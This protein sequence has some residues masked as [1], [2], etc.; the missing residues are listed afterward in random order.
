[1]ITTIK[2]CFK[3]QRELP[4][5]SFY[6]HPMMTGGR[7]G[8]CK[9]CARKDVSENRAKKADYYNEF[10]RARYHALSKEDL[11]KRN[12]ANTDKLKLKPGYKELKKQ[13]IDRSN[14]KHIDKHRAR[15]ALKNAVRSGIVDRPEACWHCG[16]QECVHGHHSAYDLPLAVTWL[17]SFCHGIAHRLT[18]EVL[19]IEQAATQQDK[20]VA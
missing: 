14:Q 16:S 17:C 10:D 3:C 13:Y 7:L 8:K 20:E 11:R 9:D 12:K 2:T 15:T 5:E 4:V 6:R 18:N 19:R 1:M